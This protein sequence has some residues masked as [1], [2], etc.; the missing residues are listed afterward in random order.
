MYC[1]ESASKLCKQASNKQVIV[2]HKEYLQ[3]SLA[4]LDF[5]TLAVAVTLSQRFNVEHL[6]LG[7]ACWFHSIVLFLLS[8]SEPANQFLPGITCTL[9]MAQPPLLVAVLHCCL[10]CQ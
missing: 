10:F 1:R 6:A 8:E 9:L 4:C 5:K 7:A 2:A 3:S